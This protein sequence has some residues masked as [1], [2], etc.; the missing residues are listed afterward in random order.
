MNNKK[1]SFSVFFLV[2]VLLTSSCNK[3]LSVDP[4]RIP[5]M[6]VNNEILYLDEIERILPDNITGKDS[7]NFVETYKKNWAV[8]ILLYEKAL[9]NIRST[10]E[11]DRL[12]EEYR[13]E[14]IINSYQQNLVSQKLKNISND[15]LLD[16]YEKEK[17]N[18]VLEEPIIKGVYVQLPNKAPNQ[19]QLKQWLTDMNDKTL[20]KIEKYCIQYASNY[21]FFM[22]EWVPYFR[23]DKLFPNHVDWTDPILTRGLVEQKD[24][25]HVYFL[26]ITGRVNPGSIEPFEVA[27]NK[28]MNILTHREKMNYIKEFENSLY[29]NAIKKEKI[30]F[31]K[32]NEEE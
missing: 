1:L 32:Q 24:S 18:F 11:I 28:I 31:F 22:E 29:N 12:T 7:I 25:T 14:L 30:T 10:E 13:K 6:A 21:I 20:E 5:I 8:N 17:H 3:I 4:E 15:A 23:V 9:Q 2:F 16:V 26:R 27:Q 19:K